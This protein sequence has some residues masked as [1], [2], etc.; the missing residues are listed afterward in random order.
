MTV[1]EVIIKK[2]KKK[3]YSAVKLSGAANLKIDEAEAFLNNKKMPKLNEQKILK[4]LSDKKISV[5][6]LDIPNDKKKEVNIE[7]YERIIAECAKRLAELESENYS[8]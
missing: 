1:Q 2:L 8:G 6:Q 5:L 7:A 3:G 4:F